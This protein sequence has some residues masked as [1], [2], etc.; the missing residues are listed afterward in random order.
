MSESIGLGLG[1]AAKAQILRFNDRDEFRRGALLVSS[2]LASAA[3][4]LGGILA[5]CSSLDGVSTSAG[6]AL[7][8]T[9][10][11]GN[12]IPPAAPVPDSAQQGSNPHKTGSLFGDGGNASGDAQA[13]DEDLIPNA[14]AIDDTSGIPS[15]TTGKPGWLRFVPSEITITDG[16]GV[17][18]LFINKDDANTPVPVM[19]PLNSAGGVRRS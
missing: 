8:I 4:V 10:M 1:K 17:T 16:K 2:A 13:G 14:L 5:A 19:I 9:W 3:L 18:M 6:G 7:G 15:T 11:G 12:T